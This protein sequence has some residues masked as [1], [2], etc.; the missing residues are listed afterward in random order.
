MVV[1]SLSVL[2]V[3][4]AVSMTDNIDRLDPIVRMSPAMSTTSKDLFGYAA[5]LHH[6]QVPASDDSTVVAAEKTR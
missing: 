3:H 1:A 5:V 2:E 4:G 6:L